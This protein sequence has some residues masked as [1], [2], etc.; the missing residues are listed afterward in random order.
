VALEWQWLVAYSSGCWRRAW[1]S[2][3]IPDAASKV[4]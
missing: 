2:G 4:T 1:V 3:H